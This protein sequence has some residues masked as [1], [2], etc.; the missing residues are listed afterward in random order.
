MSPLTAYVLG[1]A[2]IPAL[3]MIA[4]GAW[5]LLARSTTI[6]AGCRYCNT[7]WSPAASRAPWWVSDTLRWQWHKATRAHRAAGVIT[8]STPHTKGTSR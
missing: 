3:T 7:R 6:E 8:T 4:L 5:S 2:T 1:I